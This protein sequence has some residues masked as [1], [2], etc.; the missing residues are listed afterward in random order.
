MGRITSNVGLITGLPITD[1]VDKLIQVAGAPRDLLTS[2]NQGLQQQQLAINSLSTRLLSLRFDLS[3]LNVSGPFQA[4]EVTSQDEDVL[5]TSLS[6]GGNPP[7]GSFKIKPVLTASSQQLISQRFD[8]LD[9]I[10]GT[11][12]LSFGFGGFVDKGISL[13]ELNSGSGVARGEIRITDLAGNSA[14]IDLSLARTVDDVINVINSD[15]RINITATV[16]GDTFVLTD[17]IGGA[18][19]LT[20]Q[21]VNGG[22]TAVDL[23]LDGISTT[24][25][26]VA[27]GDVFSL[28]ADTK[29]STLNDYNGVRITDDTTNIDDLTISLL[30]NTSA[31]VD[32]SGSTT[33]GDV[34]D[35]INNDTDFTGKL[36]AAISA[37]GNRLELTDLTAGAGTFAVT[38]GITGSAADDLGLTTTAAGG[39]IT[40]SR[41]TSGLRD[42]LVSS[43]Q[44]G[45]GIV[46]GSI[47][48]TD[49][50]GGGPDTV[51][52]SPAETLSE[53]VDLINNSTAEV[54]ASI[55]AARNGISVLDTS[56]GTGN[57]V[58]ASGDGTSD[59]LGITLN[60]AQDS[61]VGSSLGRQTLSEATLLSSLNGGQGI[62]ASDIKITD[63]DGATDSIDLNTSGSEAK[64][65]GDVID[66]INASTKVSVIASINDA[67]DGIFLTNTA[68]GSA[69]LGVSDINGTLAAD[70]NLTRGSEIVDINGQDTQVINGTSSY[71][72]DL[73]DIDGSSQSISLASLNDGAGIDASDI[74]ITDS[75]GGINNNGVTVIDLNGADAGITTIGQL[76]D[77]I[78]GRAST[79]A[80]VTA[81]INSSGTGILLTDNAGGTE[82]LLV[83]DVNGTAAA[84]LKILST[85]TMTTSIDGIGLF[86]AQSASQGALEAVANKINELDAGVSASAFFDGVGFRLSL[87]VD[88]TGSANAIL[89]DPGTS[90]FEFTETSSARD[91]LLV[92]GEQGIAGSG[93]LISSPTNEFD[94]VIS[95]VDLSVVA[96]SATSVDVSVTQTDSEIVSLVEDFVDSYNAL[97]SDLDGLTDFN[98]ADLTTGLLFGTN[99]ALRV[100]TELSRLVTDRYTGV[101]SFESLEEIGLSVDGEGKLQFDVAQLKE[102]FAEDAKS[103]QAL[104]VE[105]DGGIVAK[106]DSA[107]E[108]LAGA[109]NGLLTNRNDS[110]QATIDINQDRIDRFNESLDRQREVL[111]LQFFQLEQVIAGLQSSQTALS[112]LQPLAPLVST[113][114]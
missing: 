111:L 39:V 54:T 89:L 88:Q 30:D 23:G 44:G 90:G 81:S 26:T 72:I 16:D 55:N 40:G 97:R 5:T 3:K 9:D 13:S 27:G 6:S 79:G 84:D 50:A 77:V 114:R 82:N 95:G 75:R 43:L 58:I 101:G 37:D 19:T 73:T 110:L 35:A 94:Q 96:A 38:N 33:L 78:N 64:T 4:R 109:D 15:T 49:R 69:T 108:S 68:T 11:G 104:F 100:D 57:L 10:Q 91:A 20:V 22:T 113:S 14:V 86:T 7:L 42:T 48:I 62:T 12:S 65:I 92:L 36:T 67:G 51:D 56:G 32:L 2:R 63:S 1:T 83:E 31:G 28:H 107:I 34:V 41:I 25:S 106:F 21:E 93:I 102:A 87:V 52:L 60:V 76:V 71:A 8:T 103:L 105:S 74:R 98:E 29:L 46:L 85:E 66:A 61:S 112:A 80:N 70:L 45:D 18:S 47:D 99:E 17:D 59:A 53:V 24:A